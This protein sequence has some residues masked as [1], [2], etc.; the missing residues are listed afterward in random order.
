MV[1]CWL[2]RQSSLHCGT[3]FCGEVSADG[4]ESAN[5]VGYT[6]TENIEAEKWYLLGVNF[7]SVSGDEIPVQDFIKGVPPAATDG[8]AETTDAPQLQ[9]WNGI[10][11]QAF[12][13]VDEDYDGETDCW[14]VGGFKAT[15]TLAIG[16]SVWFRTPNACDAI[17]IS[18]QVANPADTQVTL[19]PNKWNL[20]ANPYPKTFGLNDGAF[21]LSG[22]PP[23]ITD[24][25]AET[26]DA[27]LIQVWTGIGYKEFYYVDEDYDGETDCWVV[28]GFKA[29]EKIPV[30]A[31]FW[32]KFSG[33]ADA[34][35]TF[36]K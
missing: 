9:V 8:D 15:E 23:A 11:Y 16:Q 34:T 10:G 13:Y 5:V 19:V 31:G 17:T 29:T 27:P 24:G 3:V 14:V 26:T 18:G 4:I 36:N 12:Y 33:D 22:I 32:V 2:F 6:S 28:G 1:N 20:V 30:G 7:E 25:D 35:I 21:T